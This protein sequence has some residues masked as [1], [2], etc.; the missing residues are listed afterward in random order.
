MNTN[1]RKDTLFNYIF[2][3]NK[4]IKLDAVIYEYGK[5][6]QYLVHRANDGS[7]CLYN[8]DGSKNK[9]INVALKVFNSIVLCAYDEGTE[10]EFIQVEF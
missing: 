4:T 6:T 2:N 5:D 1:F 8:M 3:S 7:Y 9:S 10:C